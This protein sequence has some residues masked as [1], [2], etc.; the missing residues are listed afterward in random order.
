[1]LKKGAIRECQPHQNQFVGTLFLAGKKDGGNRPVISLKKI[2][3]LIPYQHF[4]MGF[5]SSKVHVATRGLHVQS[6]NDGCLLF[7]SLTQKLQGERS[8]SMV[9]E[10]RRIPLSVFLLR[11]SSKN[12]CQNFKSA[13]IPTK[14]TE[15]QNS[16]LSRRHVVA[17]KVN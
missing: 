11:T 5:T 14:E 16:Y 1:M 8:F 7:G 13:N 6:R 17:V 12:F 4:R 9:R 2:N 10:V 15:Y 3:K